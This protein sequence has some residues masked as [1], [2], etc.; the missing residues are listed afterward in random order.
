MMT[1]HNVVLD[2][3]FMEL[4]GFSVDISCLFQH[5]MTWHDVDM[6]VLTAEMIWAVRAKQAEVN[7]SS[8]TVSI[9]ITT[10]HTLTR[11]KLQTTAVTCSAIDAGCD[12]LDRV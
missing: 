6:R 2:G 9:F 10:T 12:C 3:T 7:S 5:L 8:Y 1:G 11:P 4:D